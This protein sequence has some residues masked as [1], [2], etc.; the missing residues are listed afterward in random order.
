MGD[1]NSN[2]ISEDAFWEWLK[3]RV[4]P[5]QL[6]E[7]YRYALMLKD[8]Y[9]PKYHFSSILEEMARTFSDAVRKLITQDK[10]YQNKY[11]GY[12]RQFISSLLDYMDFYLEE[13]LPSP[14][15][16]DNSRENNEKQIETESSLQ[17]D[18]VRKTFLSYIG[19][20]VP[21][22]KDDLY[23]SLEKLE[24]AV[25]WERL[26]S[27]NMDEALTTL[28]LLRYQ[29]K[30]KEPDRTDKKVMDL[31]EKFFTQQK[32]NP[33]WSVNRPSDSALTDSGDSPVSVSL[34]LETNIPSAEISVLEPEQPQ[35][36][37][38]ETLEKAKKHSVYEA[39]LD[40]ISEKN[41]YMDPII[42]AK[43]FGTVA[44]EL[45]LTFDEI[46]NEDLSK[47]YQLRPILE[48][49]NDIFKTDEQRQRYRRA[50]KYYD[51]FLESRSEG[52]RTEQ[53]PGAGFSLTD[54]ANEI[55]DFSNIG[56]ISFCRPVSVWYYGKKNSVESWRSLYGMLC[57]FLRFEHPAVFENMRKESLQGIGGLRLVDAAHKNKLIVSYSLGN[58]YFIEVNRNAGD[59]I[60]NLKYILDRCG[61]DYHNV[62]I[63]YTRQKTKEEKKGDPNDDIR[64]ALKNLSNET[65]KGISAGMVSKRINGR[66]I[67]FQVMQIL[68]QADWA[69]KIGHNSYR[70]LQQGTIDTTEHEN[71]DIIEPV[72]SDNSLQQGENSAI[73]EA[74]TEEMQTTSVSEQKNDGSGLQEDSAITIS[75]A[76]ETDKESEIKTNEKQYD[77]NKYYDQFVAYL[78]AEGVDKDLISDICESII[79]FGAWH[80]HTKNELFNQALNQCCQIEGEMWKSLPDVPRRDFL[81]F[82]R[83]VEY[84]G[85]F[86]GHLKKQENSITSS[87]PVSDNNSQ[88]STTDTELITE[89][90]KNQE[91]SNDKTEKHNDDDFWKWL[92]ARVTPTYITELFSI[93]NELNSVLASIYHYRASVFDEML[94]SSYEIVSKEIFSA[95]NFKQF[96]D[97]YQRKRIS[98]Y[99]IFIRD[100]ISSGQKGIDDVLNT[101]EEANPDQTIAASTVKID[102]LPQVEGSSINKDIFSDEQTMSSAD[103]TD[104][105]AHS[106]CSVSELDITNPEDLSDTTPIYIQLY[107]DKN[108]SVKTWE[109]VYVQFLS[110]LNSIKRSALFSG[111]KLSKNSKNI[112]IGSKIHLRSFKNY[113]R[114]PGTSLYVRT[115]GS[116]ND[117]IAR[118]KFLLD[119]KN[120]PY[121]KLIITYQDDVSI[122]PI[123]EPDPIAANEMASFVAPS[124]PEINT[125]SSETNGTN[126]AADKGISFSYPDAP[127]AQPRWTLQEA[128]VLLDAYLKVQEHPEQRKA[129][130]Q[131]VSDQ[132]RQMAVNQGLQI[133][134]TYRNYDGIFLRMYSMETAWIGKD[135]NHFSSTK[136]FTEI[137]RLYREEKS[138]FDKFLFEAQKSAGIAS[139]ITKA[140]LITKKEFQNYMQ[141]QGVSLPNRAYYC[142]CLENMAGDFKETLFGRDVEHCLSIV[143]KITSKIEAYGTTSSK[144]E[145]L[146]YF[147]H[148]L[149]ESQ[150]VSATNN[151]DNDAGL[152]TS[153]PE[154]IIDEADEWILAELKVRKIAYQDNRAKK[155]CLWI[156]GG[157]ELGNFIREC[158]AHGYRMHYKANGCKA[159]PLKPVWWTNN[160]HLP[161]AKPIVI[162]EEPEPVKSDNKLQYREILTEQFRNGYIPGIM[163]RKRFK[164]SWQEKY[165]EEVPVDDTAL[166]KI[167]REICIEGEGRYYIPEAMMDDE[168]KKQVMEYLQKRTDAGDKAVSYQVA[169][170]DLSG[171][172]VNTEISTPEMLHSWLEHV[173][174][175]QYRFDKNYIILQGEVYFDPEREIRDYLREARVPVDYDQICRDLSHIQAD[176]IKYILTFNTPDL[177]YNAGNEWFEAGILDLSDED[178]RKIRSLID[179]NLDAQDYVLVRE[180]YEDLCKLFP[181]VSDQL[182]VLSLYGVQNYLKY[183]LKSQ[184]AFNGQVISSFATPIDTATIY[185]NFARRN[186]PF[187]FEDLHRLYKDLNTPIYYDSVFSGCIRI[188][189]SDYVRRDS[190]H[191]DIE[192]TDEILGK[193]I[194]GAYLPLQDFHSFDMLPACGV[195]WNIFVLE[196]YVYQFSRRFKLSHAGFTADRC[197]GAIVRQISGINDFKED[198]VPLALSTGNV[199]LTK[200]DA[201]DYLSGSGLIAWKKLDITEKMLQKAKMLRSQ[202]GKN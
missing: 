30:Y 129:L 7:M 192:Q 111:M 133:S 160:I 134:D 71:E 23:V 66:L 131:Q 105:Q 47:C 102:T 174:K 150:S 70:Y 120:I 8:Y 60:R 4:T 176:T 64:L 97:D 109:D 54:P 3:S 113:R 188:N 172:L 166:E 69:E 87:E 170:E 147:E 132:L 164:K 56:D 173:A 141:Q 45:N 2:L 40:F 28:K 33:N 143:E 5:R 110:L 108:S 198:L 190:L 183:K 181:E 175:G 116:A 104:T 112:D 68:D 127:A 140:R 123:A 12:D 144:K 157:W 93:S 17:P 165:H 136:T 135:A 138:T 27:P 46:F 124:T 194:S 159:F 146:S 29:Q 63:E 193:Y 185:R 41:D 35:P 179:K 78:E 171:L 91:K 25:G 151:D 167:I 119:K 158:N 106:G 107:K 99:L 32:Q 62:I 89:S 122:S 137:V 6:S 50:L 186:A 73:I 195:P 52:H 153:E 1:N 24:K 197:A 80:K 168:Q 196:Q 152:M 96:F 84:Y 86:L 142:A 130:V 149:S 21:W 31:L 101:A 128:A 74:Q 103:K 20:N 67:P 34:E 42:Y 83:A 114:I 85:D 22:Q 125:D 19:K 139:N 161:L 189:V 11:G 117:Y 48:N 148:F 76:K 15:K 61:V 36:D 55:I 182:A 82:R 155:G 81:R 59:L 177:L 199:L 43:S 57:A 118:I 51:L 200:K 163:S 191:F 44:S 38:T 121:D 145:A 88:Y 115:E 49:Q 9:V 72:I 154:I 75:A 126:D 178:F 98:E 13:N 95:P 39:F 90:E 169:F 10:H 18:D 14:Q 100:Y 58:G 184:Y 16:E 156:L 202:K 53:A 37:T 77:S 94:I 162:P 26:F 180:L 201:L 79:D 92:D 65:E 187:S